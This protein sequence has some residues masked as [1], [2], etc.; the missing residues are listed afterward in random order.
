MTQCHPG[1]DCG[2]QEGNPVGMSATRPDGLGRVASCTNFDE[3][4]D[5]FVYS[6][7]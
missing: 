7:Q 3:F 1:S 6:M 2:A 5:L 4:L